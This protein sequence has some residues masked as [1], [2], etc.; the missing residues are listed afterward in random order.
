MYQSV[1]TRS[2]ETVVVQTE[3]D[4]SISLLVG[5]TGLYVL[6]SLGPDETRCVRAVLLEALRALALA[7]VTRATVTPP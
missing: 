4:G 2:G 7:D 3:A 1:E 5:R 6:A